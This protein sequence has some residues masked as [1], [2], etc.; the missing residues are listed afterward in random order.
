M[1]SNAW[2]TFAIQAINRAS[3]SLKR[4]ETKL[5]ELEDDI[6]WHVPVE[7]QYPLV[8]GERQRLVSILVGYLP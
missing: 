7:D 3:A 2:T 5:Y 6:M 8:V 1:D 4:Q